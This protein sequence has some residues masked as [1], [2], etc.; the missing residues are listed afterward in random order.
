MFTS[1]LQI[2][3]F[4]ATFW[5]I[6]SHFVSERLKCDLL[7]RFTECNFLSKMFTKILSMKVVRLL[8][9]SWLSYKWLEEIWVHEHHFYMVFCS[10]LSGSCLRRQIYVIFI[11]VFRFNVSSS[12]HVNISPLTLSFSP[13]TCKFFPNYLTYLWVH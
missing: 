12:P 8:P 7:T 4:L 1:F 9:S 13:I 10:C 2:L 5:Q 3:I 11:T 6:S